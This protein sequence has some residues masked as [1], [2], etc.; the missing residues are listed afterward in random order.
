MGRRMGGLFYWHHYTVNTGKGLFGGA[1]ANNINVPNY[2]PY[3]LPD[4]AAFA[5]YV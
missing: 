2:G 1:G 3:I 4:E 5:Y